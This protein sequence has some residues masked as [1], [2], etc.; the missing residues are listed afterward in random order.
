MR[1]GIKRTKVA[2]FDMSIEMFSAKNFRWWIAVMLFG[3]TTLN[4]LDRQTLS[5]LA[6]TIQRELGIDDMGYAT[7]TSYFLVSYTVMYAVSGGLIDLIGTR[8]SLAIAVTGWSIANI[9]HCLAASAGQLGAVRF[10]LGVFESAN[11]P[12]GIKAVAEWFPLR[13]R[14]LGIGIFAAGG[15]AGAAISAPLVSFLALAYGWRWAFVITGA[16]GFI[17]VAAWLFITQRGQRFAAVGSSGSDQPTAAEVMPP[18]AWRE[19]LYGLLKL[20]QTW[21][22]VLIRV[23]TDPIVYFISF[24]IPK[25]L[26]QQHGFSLADIGRY[27]WMPFL[28]LSLGNIFGGIIASQLVQAGWTLNIARKTLMVG[29]SLLLLVAAWVVAFAPGPV[30]AI[31]ALTC[32]S[33]GHGLWGNI[34]V[35]AEVF[36]NK[37]VAFVSG[38]G[39][40]CGGVAGI[41]SQ[42]AIGAA[43]QHGMYTQVFLIVS[44]CPLLAF[45][46]VHRLIGQLGVGMVIAQV[47]TPLR[48]D[49]RS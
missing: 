36:A 16:I 1:S 10:L 45:W 42:F 11:F 3:S 4:Y 26:V 32:I 19:S 37:H 25:Y 38:L 24:W 46:A 47:G 15:A 9:L 35:P 7:I 17:W 12:A 8:R 27:A 21:G 48:R 30:S 28:G 20:R 14:A 33:L 43:A 40:M 23:F 31:V 22:C 6:S 44:V 2:E 41:I 34:A 5:V 29:A 39:G 13:E 18:A 49:N